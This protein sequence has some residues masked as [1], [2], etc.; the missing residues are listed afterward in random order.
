MA[1]ALGQQACRQ[2]LPRDLPTRC[3]ASL[4]ELALAHAD[5]SYT[6]LLARLARV[7]VL[8]L[9]DWGLGAVTDG[10][11]RTCS[12]CS[13][14]ATARARRSS[15]ASCRAIN[16]TT[17]LG[18]PTIADAILDR[19]VHRAHPITL[20]GPSRRKTRPAAEAAAD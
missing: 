18:D 19:L 5:G 17:Y 11:A 20:D 9:D 6:A 7:D 3:R 16:G 2:G 8:V 13:R 4:Q 14:I 1:C 15:R 12:R 10:S